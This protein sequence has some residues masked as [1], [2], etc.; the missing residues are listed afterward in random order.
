MNFLLRTPFFRLLLALIAG[1]VTCHYF[2]L[3]D[4]TMLV[5]AVPAFLSVFLS[6]W[7]KEVR[8]A[9]RLR[10]GFGAGLVV[11]VYL[12]GYTLAARQESQLQ[13]DFQN[14]PQLYRLELVE[15]PEVK[16]RSVLCVADTRLL[17]SVPPETAH[18]SHAGKKPVALFGKSPVSS[19]TIVYLQKDSLA[20]LLQRGDILLARL[21]FQPPAPVQNPEGFEYAAFLRRKGIA[22][23]AYADSL[24]WKQFSHSENPGLRHWAEKARDQLLAIYQNLNLAP[25]DFAVLAALTLGYK[26]ELEPEIMLHY[27]ASGAMHILSVSGLHVG[28]I[29]LIVNSLVSMVFRK[30][31]TLILKTVCIILA[32]WLY[33]FITGLSPSV[34]RASAMFSMVTLGK[35]LGRQAQIYNTISST[36]FILLLVNPSYLWDVGFQLSYTAVLG[37][38]YFQPQLSP[39]LAV[40]NKALKWLWDLTSVSLAAQLGTLP[41]ALF[42]FNQFPN[43][44]LLTNYIAIPLSTF[45]IYAAVSYLVLFFVPVAGG[46]VGW[47][48]AQLLALLNRAIAAIHALPGSVT[49]VYAGN[50]ELL[51]MTVLL[52][53]WIGYAELKRYYFITV[54]LTAV[55][56]FPVKRII[57]EINSSHRSEL[58]VYTDRK[59]L[60]A[61]LTKGRQEFVLTSDS[62]SFVKLAGKYRLK[63]RLNN[64][65]FIVDSTSCFSLLDGKRIAF[66]NDDT[67]RRKKAV[68]PLKLD[69]LIVN[70]MKGYKPTELMSCFKPRVC[71]AGGAL[72]DYYI[73]RLQEECTAGSIAFFSL[74]KSGAYREHLARNEKFASDRNRTS[75]NH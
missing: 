11:L 2:R 31:S 20:L 46:V 25:D 6:F 50:F 61:Q 48:L 57:T 69:Y 30:P 26:E 28:V 37:I 62:A 58:I 10:W 49:Q 43:Y 41:L 4:L 39:L 34:I 1:I 65:Q 52:I 7:V 33:A 27:S 18:A 36:A 68:I 47:G 75:S 35:A 44:F 8:W 14:E 63:N 38:V 71:I 9:H 72:S 24:N 45:V 53:C 42:Y 23:T 3:F 16:A 51:L 21:H 67:Y 59:A 73:S 56:M 15:R 5:L 22:A 55:L 17:D 13:F 74:R 32:L 54:A 70:T 19:K 12:L 64:Q 29:F 66:I 60:H 40:S